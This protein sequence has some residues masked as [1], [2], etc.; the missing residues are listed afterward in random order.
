MFSRSSALLQ[1]VLFR[2]FP[3]AKLVVLN[4]EKPLKSLNVEMVELMLPEYRKLHHLPAQSVVVVMKGAG[5]KAFCAGGDVVSIV[6]DEPRDST[7]GATL[8]GG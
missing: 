3:L 1:S 7:D 6:K 8:E 5:S 4:R 2:D